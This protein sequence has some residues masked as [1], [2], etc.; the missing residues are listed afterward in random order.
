MPGETKQTILES[1]DS[2]HEKIDAVI[3]TTNATLGWMETINRFL[4]RYGIKK[5]F[6][7]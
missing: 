3:K 7:D 2:G 5:I 4:V 1:M 6:M